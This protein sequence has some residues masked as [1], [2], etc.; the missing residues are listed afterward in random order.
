MWYKIWRR[1]GSQSHKYPLRRKYVIKT[2]YG[3]SGK[4]PCPFKKASK[5]KEMKE[6]DEFGGVEPSSNGK[7]L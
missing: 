2:M 5:L 7:S 6:D 1:L 4:V 3:G